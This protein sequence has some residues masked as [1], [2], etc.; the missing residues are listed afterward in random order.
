MFGIKPFASNSLFKGSSA[1]DDPNAAEDNRRARMA[2][3][4]ILCNPTV[5]APIPGLIS[6]R[7]VDNAADAV[8]ERRQLEAAEKAELEHA[9]TEMWARLPEDY[10]WLKHWEYV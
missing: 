6:L 4:N 5:T 8:K 2:L 9:T 10:L 3:R 1:P 7:Q